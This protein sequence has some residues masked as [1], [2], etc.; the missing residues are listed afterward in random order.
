MLQ[1]L[2]PKRD[3]VL[4]DVGAGTGSI[5]NRVAKYCDNVYAL[6]PNNDR[7]EFIKAHYPEVKA[8]AGQVG[9][10]PFPDS[11]FNKIY[12]INAFHHFPVAE[13][14]ID[15]MARVLKPTGRILVHDSNPEGM[16]LGARVEIKIV[17]EQVKFLPLAQ[18]RDLVEAQGLRTV[19]LKEVFSSYFLL[20]EKE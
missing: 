5:A 7:V 8:F 13:A 18:L 19:Q 3:E 6:D 2:D 1:L 20:A 15:E 14:A 4:L 16:S 12:I 9:V 17:K 10:I 11:Y